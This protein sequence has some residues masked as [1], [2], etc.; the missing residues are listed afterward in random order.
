MLLLFFAYSLPLRLEDVILLP[1]NT[2]QSKEA[3]VM[4][5][6]GHIRNKMG[7]GPTKYKDLCKTMGLS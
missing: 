2:L 5:K 7:G 6:E 4:T 3:E 1:E